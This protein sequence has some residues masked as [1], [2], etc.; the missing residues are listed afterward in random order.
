M[1]IIANPY[2]YLGDQHQAGLDYVIQILSGGSS[3]S[4]SSSSGSTSITIDQIVQATVAYI[5][6][7]YG[8]S[9]TSVSNLELNI[10]I[11]DAVV[12]YV[13]SKAGALPYNS[14]QKFFIFQLLE[15]IQDVPTY[16]LQ[17][18]IEDIED[19]IVQSGM[20][21]TF[22][23]QLLMAT[24]IGGSDFTYWKGISAKQGYYYSRVSL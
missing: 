22:Q 5:D 24:A 2:Q 3:S 14:Q 17:S 23:N 4:S 7:V 19:N 6:S 1:A 16:G 9:L 11:T 21:S 15:G 13:N 20:T 18:Y 10:I 8:S 12:N